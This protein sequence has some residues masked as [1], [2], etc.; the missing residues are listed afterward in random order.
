[1]SYGENRITS[2]NIIL[3]DNANGFGDLVTNYWMAKCL[4]ITSSMV[5]NLIITYEWSSIFKNLEPEYNERLDYQNI[6]NVNIYNNITPDNI[7]EKLKI[8]FST[9][10]ISFSSNMPP[11]FHLPFNL[12]VRGDYP[13]QHKYK[14]VLPNELMIH[15]YSQ[16]NDSNLYYLLSKP[17]K[18]N[19]EKINDIR[20]KY[21]LPNGVFIGFAYTA[22]C[23]FVFAY[24]DNIIK[25]AKMN[26]IENYIIIINEHS[27]WKKI[28]GKDDPNYKAFKYLYKNYYSVL[29]TNCE[30]KYYETI[31]FGDINVIISLTNLPILITG[32]MSVTLAIQY[33]KQFIYDM[34]QP[35]VMNNINKIMQI[36]EVNDFPIRIR[37]RIDNKYLHKYFIKELV[38]DVYDKDFD[39]LKIH[40]EELFNWYDVRKIRDME[41]SS[42]NKY[43]KALKYMRKKCSLVNEMPRILNETWVQFL[44]DNECFKNYKGFYDFFTNESKK[45]IFNNK[46]FGATNNPEYNYYYINDKC[47]LEF[48]TEEISQNIYYYDIYHI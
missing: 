27:Y 11:S 17:P 9:A 6:N 5:I 16:N 36:N 8:T 46:S 37:N 47:N 26:P 19:R 43:F 15:E 14:I 42:Y 12:T 3:P 28:G 29:P 21:E 1:M 40:V 38:Y 2:L 20:T 24:L 34:F 41:N 4:A 44:K 25:I 18:F 35:L 10:H 32:D 13:D 30:I 45:Y 23:A 39:N 48:I 7:Y 31:P 22:S 33:N